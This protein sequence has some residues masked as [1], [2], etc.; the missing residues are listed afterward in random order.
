MDD[1]PS[2][3]GALRNRNV[4]LIILFCFLDNACFSLWSAQLLPVLVHRLGGDHAVGWSAAAC[5]MAQIA[6]A[7]VVGY[8]G[9]KLPRIE[10]IR[11]AFCCGILAVAA[12]LVAVRLLVL[13]AIYIT[14]VLWGVYIGMVSTSTEALFAD[15]VLSGQRAFI[16]NVKWIV[17]TMCYCVGYTVALLM[18]LQKGNNWSIESIQL[19]MTI[20][21]AVHPLAH[22]VL[23]L[24]RDEDL[25]TYDAVGVYSLVK[26]QQRQWQEGIVEVKENNERVKVLASSLESPLLN[27]INSL[28]VNSGKTSPGHGRGGYH[29]GSPG[30]NQGEPQCGENGV[31]SG[32]SNSNGNTLDARRF[33]GVYVSSHRIWVLTALPYVLCFTEFWMAVGAGMTVQYLTIFLINTFG[34]APT[35]LLT[36]YIIISC[37][38]ALCSTVLRYVGEH[39]VGR[40]PAVITVRLIGTT[41]LALLA[42]VVSKTTP[43][44]V[45]LTFFIARNAAMNSTMGITRSLIM[46]C[47]PK[48]SRAKWSAF[49]SVSSLTWAGSAVIGGYISDAK[50]YQYTFFVTSIIHYIGILILVPAAIATHG[51][52][53]HL[54]QV[55]REEHNS[56]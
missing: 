14:Q 19:V 27:K 1:Q 7:A 16:Y 22:V 39:F 20:G 38:T 4:M 50:G 13:P 3:G 10:S 33:G 51:M 35:W 44:A 8:A 17:Q 46:D 26:D 15:S 9:D 25:L 29:A 23:L 54:S 43:L 42:I 52:E 28:T 45:V 36:S 40:L 11:S 47:V 24:L 56:E 31:F 49:E 37:S 32:S 12:T 41:F 34:I 6:G 5:G 53:R 55:K 48:S 30:A 18:L 2:L 21:L